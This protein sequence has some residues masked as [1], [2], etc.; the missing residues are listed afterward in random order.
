MADIS[1][2]LVV[3]LRKMSGQGMMDCK[4]ALQETDG[5]I[6]EAMDLLR[7]KGLATLAKRAGRDTSEGLVVSKVS[8][9]G[10]TAAMAT[11][12]CETDFVAKSDDFV[13]TAQTLADVALACP[14]DEGIENV[15][16]VSANG[17]KFNDIITELV[18]KTGEKTQVGDYAKFK[19]EGPGLISTYIHFNEKVGTML[20][21]D[22][23]NEALAVDDTIKQTASDIAMHITATKPLA[24]DKDQ[25]DSETIEREKAIFAEQVKNKPAN[26]IDK[27]VEGKINKFYA[28]NCLLQ[29]AFVKD[30][31]KSVEQVLTETAKQ[32]GGEAKIK[33]FVRFEVG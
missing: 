10:K 25:I 29:Q 24:L 18:S 11:L 2:A 32:A 33:R 9:D 17:R 8:P 28:E 30:D 31:S 13:K 26:I 14:A 6:D 20:Q 5:D 19:L 3:K 12:C 16:E 21:I 22:T 1:A 23:S 7:K 4:K 27:I 15:L